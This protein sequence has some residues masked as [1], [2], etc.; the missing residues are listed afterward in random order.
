MMTGL[1]LYRRREFI[2]LVGGAAIA[3]PVGAIAQSTEK[4]RRIGV[5]MGITSIDPGAKP[6]V[7]VFEKQLQ[8]LRWSDQNIRID[9]RW[10]SNDAE[11]LR[12]DARDLVRLAPDLIVADTTAALTA[13]RPEAREIPV[14]FLRVSDPVGAGFIGSLARPGDNITGI[15]N[16]EFP[17]GGKWLELLKEIA[18]RTARITVLLDPGM[19]AHAGLWHTIEA[20]APAFSVEARQVPVRDSL[21]LQH[22]IVV[23]ERASRTHPRTASHLDGIACERVVRCLAAPHVGFAGAQRG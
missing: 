11:R 5:L 14:V 13:L 10:I 16:F 15:T 4:L 3:W 8:E 22:A 20:A 19:T 12:A 17:M 23:T 6:R 2:A 7:A 1:F 18:P 21:E 9:Y